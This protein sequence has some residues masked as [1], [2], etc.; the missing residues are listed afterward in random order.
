[1]NE[2]EA[3]LILQA[4]RPD[5]S[6]AADP[7]FAEALAFAQSHPQLRAWF[8]QEYALDGALSAKLDSIQPPA[9]L[10]DSIIAA[11]LASRPRQHWWKA[12]VWLAAAAAVAL[13]LSFTVRSQFSNAG[14]P[15]A[16]AFAAFALDDLAHHHDQHQGHP[17]TILDVQANL[18]A[19]TTALPGHLKL[20]LKDLEQ[21]HC[22]TARFAGRDV[23]EI[24]FK[25]E[26]HW[27]HLYATR[28]D[29][30]APG[31]ADAKSLVITKERF[32]ATAWKDSNQIYA[33][34]ASSDRDV[35]QRLL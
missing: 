10:R 19:S 22:R 18:A 35:L 16:Q 2:Q 24:C 14:G 13:L 11:G 25:R 3:K 31:A 8:E 7:R 29:G 26:G 23:F 33:L 20:D 27:Y 15:S 6:D 9:G 17:D 30:F 4:Y 21:K 12:P 5:G 1:M 32:A 34:V 28:L